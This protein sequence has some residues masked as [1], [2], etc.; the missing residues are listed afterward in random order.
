MGK[1][2][3]HWT[4]W[5]KRPIICRSATPLYLSPTT[6]RRRGSAIIQAVSRRL[7]TEAARVRAR[8]RLCGICGGQSGTGEGFLRVLWFPLPIRIPP[9]A[10]QSSSSSSIIWG[11]YN[12]P[13]SGRSTKWTQSHPIHVRQVYIYVCWAVGSLT[14]IQTDPWKCV[15]TWCYLLWTHSPSDLHGVRGCSSDHPVNLEILQLETWLQRS[16]AESCQRCSR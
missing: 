14:N 4:T 15:R 11:W 10:P 7:P 1:S 5:P 8:V 13:N 3:N 6:V 12:R 9:I 16:V 2:G